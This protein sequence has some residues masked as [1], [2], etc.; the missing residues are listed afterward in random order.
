MCA[1]SCPSSTAAPKV[2]QNLI[3]LVLPGGFNI[4]SQDLISIPHRGAWGLGY[5]LSRTTSENTPG[6]FNESIRRKWPYIEVDVALTGKDG[7]GNY[8][9]FVGHYFD[10][11]AID[12]APGAVP[13]KYA[14]D[15]FASFRMRYRDGTPN[16]N[17]DAKVLLISQLIAWAKEND[18]ILLIDPKVQKAKAITNEY[19]LIIALVLTEAR[20]QNALQNIIIKTTDSPSD[21]VTKMFP[22]IT[23][24]D[25]RQYYA[26]RFLWNPISEVFYGTRPKSAV[27]AFIDSWIKFADSGRQIATIEV[28]LFN[29]TDWSTN[30]FVRGGTTY[31]N[32]I[33]Y[34]Y[35]G[36]GG[37]HKRAGIWHIDPMS[38]RGTFGLKYSAQMIGN[39]PTDQRGNIPIT[40]NYY[41]ALST[42]VTTNRPD[43]W[44]SIAR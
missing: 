2:C 43:V 15:Q 29:P 18:A 3:D 26:G 38:P 44:D 24:Y 20:A 42:A 13:Q 31:R 7:G 17:D 40:V 16:H 11:V 34:L 8:N 19:E 32:I 27:L 1:A 41:G 6:A 23:D 37:V 35:R 21:A 10:M 14:P 28:G 25:Y 5:P 36:N 39:T 4:T 9:V 33:D 22:A 30:S 12:G